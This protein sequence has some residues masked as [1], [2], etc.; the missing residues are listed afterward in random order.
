MGLGALGE[1]AVPG[2]GNGRADCIR[3]GGDRDHHQWRD[4][5]DAGRGVRCAARVWAGEPQHPGTINR[6]LPGRALCTQTVVHPSSTLHSAPVGRAGADARGA[7]DRLHARLA[8]AGLAGARGQL[9]LPDAKPDGGDRPY[10]RGRRGLRQRPS[11][12]ARARGEAALSG[13]A[14]ELGDRDR[15]P[16]PAHRRGQNLEP[17]MGGEADLQRGVRL[18]RTPGHHWPR[19]PRRHGGRSDGAHRGRW[20]DHAC[21][22]RAGAGRGDPGRRGPPSQGDPGA[23]DVELT[24]PARS[25]LVACRG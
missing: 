19:G 6:R 20:A 9:G 25:G 12:P 11:A 23:T 1:P 7:G 8:A 13:A 16:G 18:R 24:W 14:V 15:R 10:H 17:E 5:G 2:A 22:C 21:G 3:A 4:L